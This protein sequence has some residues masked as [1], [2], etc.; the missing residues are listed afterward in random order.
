M[1]R[2]QI[3][4]ERG[5][6]RRGGIDVA[7]SSHEAAVLGVLAA[8]SHRV[9]GRGELQRRAGLAHLTPRRCDAL[10]VGLR[11]ACGPGVIVTVRG[12][13]W[14]CLVEATASPALPRPA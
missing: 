7:L 10:L 8:T 9:V 14:R 5:V 4:L 11:R 2:P 6:V 12:R 3:D 1:E 13:G